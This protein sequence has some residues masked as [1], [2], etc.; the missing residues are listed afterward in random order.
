[1]VFVTRDEVSWSKDRTWKEERVVPD[2][3]VADQHENTTWRVLRALEKKSLGKRR[4]GKMDL[5]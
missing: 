5:Q 4:Q 2:E 3:A 1:M